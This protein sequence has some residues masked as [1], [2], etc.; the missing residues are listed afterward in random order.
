MKLLFEGRYKS[1]FMNIINY[2]VVMQDKKS[3]ILLHM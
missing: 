2:H 3:I 1:Y